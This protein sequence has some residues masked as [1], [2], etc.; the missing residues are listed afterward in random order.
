MVTVTSGRSRMTKRT[1]ADPMNPS[2]PVTTQWLRWHG[3]APSPRAAKD[4]VPRGANRQIESSV[5]K[6]LTVRA[7]S[8][9]R[10]EMGLPENQTDESVE[11]NRQFFAGNESYQ[12]AIAEIDTYRALRL[13]LNDAIAGLENVVDI[14]NG[15]VF[16]YDVNLVKR[17]TAVDLFLDS[18]DT[19]VH[20]GHI[21]FVEGSALD[22]PLPSSSVDGVLIAMLLHHLVGD[23]VDTCLANLQKCILE[24]ARV[25]RPGGRLVLL[26]SCVP[27][28]FYMLERLVFK[29]ASFAVPIATKHPITLQYPIDLLEQSVAR[30]FSDTTVRH[31]PK[32]KYVLQ[33]G[34]KVP[35]FVTPVQPYLI[36]GKLA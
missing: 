10:W 14:G 22:L 34:M 36:T 35:S 27:T 11:G 8:T 1:N 2:P 5:L 18:I 16:D 21:K 12:T 15:G 6:T 9:P 26:E 23:T 20:P 19:T 28:W 17:I 30:V 25:L 32:G 4:S 31:I 3:S 33:F 7:E 24:A 13:A 29:P